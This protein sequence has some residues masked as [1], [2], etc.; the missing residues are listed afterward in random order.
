M[1]KICFEEFTLDLDLYELRK[2][3]EII[4]LGR[5]SFDLLVYLIENRERVVSRKQIQADVWKS[6]KVSTATIPTCVLDLRRA[7]QD[8][9][10]SPRFIS[11]VRGCGY[12]FIADAQTA[13]TTE[14]SSRLS[15]DSYRFVGRDNELQAL[16]SAARTALANGAGTV[17]LVSGEAGIGKTRLVEEFV[18]QLDPAIQRFTTKCSFIDGSPPYWPWTQLLRSA[19]DQ[20]SSNNHQLSENAKSLSS[21]FPEVLGSLDAVLGENRPVDRFTVINQWIRTILSI[22]RLG[23]LL[24][25]FE[26]IHRADSDSLA[27][28][29]CLA[30]E[31]ANNP[32]LLVITHR[33]PAFSDERLRR[34]AEIHAVPDSISIELGPLATPAI[35]SMLDPM[36]AK[37]GSVGQALLDRTSGNAF[38][39]TC[40]IRYL[41]LQPIDTQSGESLALLPLNGSEIVAKQLSDLPPKSREA[42]FAASII[43]DR[44]SLNL[45]AYT[46]R[47]TPADTIQRL[48]PAIRSWVVR[49]LGTEYEFRHS[50]LR[51]ALA[52]NLDIREK[53]G[54][55]FRI[56]SELRRRADAHTNAGRISDHLFASLPIGRHSDA[57]RF[58][59]LAARDCSS[60]FAYKKAAVYF[61]RALR[62][63]EDD[64]EASAARKCETMQE[65]AL[66]I[67][68]S[69]DRSQARKTLLAAAQ[70]AR[71]IDSPRALARCA[72]LLAPEFLS[73]EVG[74]VD[75]LL[76]GLLEESLNQ[77]GTRE[78]ATRAM[79]LARLA[80]ATQWTGTPRRVEALATE[81]L[82]LAIQS[83]DQEALTAALA[84]R[85]ESLHGTA[86]ARS[87][88]QSVHELATAAMKTGN[89][90]ARLLA[91]TIAITAYLELGEITCVEAE[92]E[93]YR[94]LASETN[95]PQYRWYPG[96][97]DSMLAM[98]RGHISEA[99]T[100]AN[101]FRRI[102]GEDADQNCIQT[103][104]CH[105]LIRSI[106]RDSAS[107]MIPLIE[108][109][110]RNQ[111]WMHVW[112]A[113][114]PW[115]YCEAQ[116][117]EKARTALDAFHEKKILSMAREPGGGVGLALL[118]EASVWL[119]DREK[120]QLLYSLVEPIT[121][122]C[123]TVGY[124]VAY[125]G[126]FARYAGLLARELGRLDDAIAHLE[127]AIEQENHRGAKSW[128]MY[129]EVDLHSTLAEA[130]P[131]REMSTA[132]LQ[133][134]HREAKRL[135]LTR[136]ARKIQER[137]GLPH[138]PT[139]SE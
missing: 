29:A 129:A 106:E 116:L 105:A 1:R 64:P 2:R 85:A 34:V 125:F 22:S 23:P 46:L 88:L 113:A 9:A 16:N 75:D 7:L 97:H 57:R 92:N 126:S 108:E 114:L 115:F 65:L 131:A 69:G 95:L 25:V 14:T 110:A 128:A 30:E 139:G 28:L 37:R 76:I 10:R 56:A 33:P 138:S 83:S 43:G 36:R 90:P 136:C 8:S 24:L 73:I 80:Q 71:D 99:E 123:A 122:Q 133:T 21:A 52:E 134:Q 89:V 40:L 55:H 13:S 63:A 107:N 48:E 42:L 32:I 58:S 100:I 117:A 66:A 61:S 72:L 96:A 47:V 91:H 44:F 87:R 5:R 20:S 4:R 59:L 111:M 79:L 135:G 94:A 121:E 17:V 101:D 81:A 84:A 51:D 78:T 31:L 127:R 19:L 6:A 45:L 109:T 18:H 93:R 82:E 119:N 103:F 120:S 53:R 41:E 62:V 104:A 12:R 15:Q 112:S 130:D 132:R 26:D 118:S 70:I 38:Y 39:L 27:L 50:L 35:E 54:I 77:L 102:G 74:V 67:L 137:I 11:N 86:N 3:E 49:D 124:G 60:R 98:L 68:Y